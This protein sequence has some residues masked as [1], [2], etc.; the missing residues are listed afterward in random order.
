MV[1]FTREEKAERKI[2]ILRSDFCILHFLKTKPPQLLGAT[3]AVLSFTRSGA[4]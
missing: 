3:A 2:I 1:L 4:V